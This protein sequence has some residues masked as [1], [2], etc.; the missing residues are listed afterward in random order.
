M[1][2][3]TPEHTPPAPLALSA[4]ILIVGVLTVY[5]HA[6][7]GADGRADH[8]GMMLVMWA[9]SAGF[10]RG[11]GFVPRNRPGRLL[12]GRG[13]MALALVLGALRLYSG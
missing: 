13:A 2:P 3:T 9:V 7:T 11:V 1:T 6:L 8:L 4:A 5:P 12:L 10:V